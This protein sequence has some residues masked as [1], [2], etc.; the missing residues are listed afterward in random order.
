MTEGRLTIGIETSGWSGSIA[1][2]ERG[3]LIGQRILDPAGRRHARTLVPEIEA[4]LSESGRAVR[5]LD[6][7]AVSIGPGSFTGLR[8][9]VVCAK[10]LAWAANAQIVAVDSFLAI[11]AQSPPDVIHVDVVGDGQRGD[12]YVGRY[13]RGDGGDWRRNGEIGIRPGDAWLS[14][15]TADSIVSGPA[16][17]RHV[18]DACKRARVLP[19]AVWTPRGETIA[20]LGERAA[21]AGRADDLWSLEPFYLRRSGAE[22]KADAAGT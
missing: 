1:L 7:V 16:L 22:E 15:L 19:P 17:E 20:L 13:Q 10:T 3:A 6:A 14:G 5:A 21:L 18:A 9:G 11:A 8:V 12:L 2:V 4:L